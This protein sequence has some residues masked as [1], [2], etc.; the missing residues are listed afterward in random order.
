MLALFVVVSACGSTTPQD[1][2]SL[3]ATAIDRDQP[4]LAWSLLSPEVREQTDYDTFVL[5]WE[6]Y[7]KQMAPI[8]NSM[9]SSARSPARVRA[10]VEYSDYDTLQLRLTKD[11]WK[12]TD[13][14]FR[15]Y[16]QD[17]PRQTV[18]SF[19]R[20]MEGRRFD[21][22]MRFIPSEYAQHMTPDDLKADFERR[23]D[24]IN[25]MI[26]ALKANMYN[27]IQ[28]RKDHAYMQYGE[29]EITLVLEG[30]VWK[31]EDPD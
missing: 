20:A 10:K 29:R 27:P 30:D 26:D 21:I 9:R 12:I 6:R 2:L 31:V 18:I 28:T 3:Y 23:P 19:V 15:F 14:L 7:K 5:N 22:V 25:E 16:A 17:T 24:E 11:G 13:G 1:T 8:I 4:E